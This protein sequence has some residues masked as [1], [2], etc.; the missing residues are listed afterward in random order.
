M[1]QEISHTT[2]SQSDFTEYRRRLEAETRLLLSGLS[3]GKFSTRL[4][5]GGFEVEGWLVDAAMRPAPVNQA[6]F[7]ALKNPMATP[8]L[9]KFNIELNN[10]PVPLRQDALSRFAHELKQVFADADTAA[11]SV[12]ARVMLNGILPTL[13]ETDCCLDN[14]SNMTRYHVLNDLIFEARKQQPLQLNIHGDICADTHNQEHLQLKHYSVMLEAGATSFQVHMQ[15]PWHEAHHYYNASIIASAAVLAASTNSPYLF[16]K[17]L[18]HETRIPLFEQSVDSANGPQRV[19]F[20]SGFVKETIG[21]CFAENLQDYPVLLPELTSEAIEQFSHLRLHNGVIW[22]WNRP[23]VGFDEDDTPHI[24]I[25]HRCLP[26]GPTIDDMVANAAF[27]YGLTE[28]LARHMNEQSVMTFQQAR[29][30][31]YAAACQGLSAPLDWCGETIPARSLILDQLLS[32]AE[33]GLAFLNISDA[34]IHHWLGIVAARV[35]SGQTGSVWQIDHIEKYSATMESMSRD[36]LIHQ[37]ESAPVH[38]WGH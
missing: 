14:M 32:M 1:G 36:Y 30:G 16:G 3:Q 11:R 12:N 23:L 15:I 31:F 21:E 6:F 38:L 29:S 20:G 5:V 27:Y 17:R 28:S 9:A 24:R 18:W 33:E 25:E 22:R 8:E 2:F 4:P 35:E 34:D 13:C 19:S 37:H 7:R 10:E 26:A